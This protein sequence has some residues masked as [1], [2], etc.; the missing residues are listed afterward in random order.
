MQLNSISIEKNAIIMKVVAN[1]QLDSAEKDLVESKVT[2]KS[3]PLPEFTEAF[4]NLGTVFCSIMELDPSWREG[5]T[6]TH[7][8]IS[9]TKQGT[10]SVTLSG[11]KQ[12]ECRSGFLHP[13]STPC[14]Q[15]D[16]ATEGESGA[17][18][19]PMALQEAVE[20]AIEQAERYMNGERSQ[21]EINFQEAKAGLQAIADKGKDATGQLAL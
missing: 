14:V 15:V 2:S 11:T 13:V 5:L 8:S 21:A 20:E 3:E 4:A 17:V 9:R 18:A 19:I 6:I 1:P 16:D 12:L 7:L 10:R